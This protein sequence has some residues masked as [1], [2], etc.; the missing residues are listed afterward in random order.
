MKVTSTF[1]T[2]SKSTTIPLNQSYRIPLIS[3][4]FPDTPPSLFFFFSTSSPRRSTS[5]SCSFAHSQT[6]PH[7]HTDTQFAVGE[8]AT[9]PTISRV[10]IVRN[11]KLCRRHDQQEWRKIDKLILLGGSISLDLELRAFRCKSSQNYYRNAL[12]S[13]SINSR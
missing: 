6:R 8:P 10:G 9:P 12:H 7:S 11:I 2:P 3:F 5:S 4:Q 13:R 1:E